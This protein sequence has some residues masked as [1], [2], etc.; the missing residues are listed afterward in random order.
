M[1]S[2]LPKSTFKVDD[3]ISYAELVATENGKFFT[4]VQ[5]YKINLDICI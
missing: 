4:A 5:F 1:K 2:F 3:I